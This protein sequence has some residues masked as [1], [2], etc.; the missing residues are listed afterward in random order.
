M[1]KRKN[2][3]IGEAKKLCDDWK[4]KKE[5]RDVIDD[6]KADLNRSNLSADEREKH[7]NTLANVY[8]LLNEIEK[9]LG[10]R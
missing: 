1:A 3:P 2:D 6:I 5:L 7:A 10:L 9:C 4:L 8:R